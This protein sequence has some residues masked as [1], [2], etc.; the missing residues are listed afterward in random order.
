MCHL[1]SVCFLSFM[2]SESTL[3][4]NN[5]PRACKIHSTSFH[6]IFMIYFTVNNTS[7]K[8][9]LRFSLYY[10]HFICTS[11]LPCKPSARTFLCPCYDYH[12][13]KRKQHHL[14]ITVCTHN[15]DQSVTV[16]LVMIICRQNCCTV[17]KHT[18]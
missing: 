13:N 18:V 15:N 7:S 8:W 10:S 5:L 12:N 3:L 9:S 1:G 11:H 14:K 4:S 16:F 17:I 6:P 2:Q